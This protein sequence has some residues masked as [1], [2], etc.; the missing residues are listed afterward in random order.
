M[1]VQSEWKL[2]NPKVNILKSGNAE[3]LVPKYK[4]TKHEEYNGILNNDM[5]KVLLALLLHQ[6]QFSC[7][8]AIRLAKQILIK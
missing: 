8:T 5:K 2:T 4:I 3:S 1:P 7:N 6:N